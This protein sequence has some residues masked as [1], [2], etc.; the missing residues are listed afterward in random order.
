MII[1]LDPG[2]GEETPGKRSPDGKFREYEYCR[3]VAK[4]V[5]EELEKD[6]YKVE[7]T[8]NDNSDTPIASRCKYVNGMCSKYGKNNILLVSIH[9]NAAGNGKNW[10]KAKGWSVFVSKNASTKSKLLA[11]CLYEEANSLGLNIRKQ[12][13]DKGYW[14]QNLGICRDTNCPACLVE[15]MFQDNKEDV[16]Y[17]LSEQGFKDIVSIYVNG[18]KRYINSIKN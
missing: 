3:K 2:H 16:A 8:V 17:M 18:I 13:T 14:V 4:K 6:G 11:E 15:N 12:Y 5:K 10:M 1:I 9:N 7:M